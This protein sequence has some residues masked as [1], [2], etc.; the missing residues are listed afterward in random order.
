MLKNYTYRDLKI[1]YDW[2]SIETL[3]VHRPVFVNAP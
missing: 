2:F 1:E 3:L